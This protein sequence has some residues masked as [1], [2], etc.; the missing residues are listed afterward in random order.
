MPEVPPPRPV[1]D[2]LI[3][4]AGISGIGCAAY[5]RRLMPQKTFGILE[6][7]GDL[8]GTWDLFR[9]PGIR[10]DSDL[11]TFAYEFKPWKSRNSMAAASEIKDYLEETADEYGIR[12]KISFGRKVIACDWSS[13]EGL[14]T[15]TAETGSGTEIWRCRWIFSAT[16]YYDYDN[17]YRPDFPEEGAFAGQIVH[18]QA[19]PRDLDYAGRRVAVIGSGATAVTLLP[20]LAEKAAHVTQVQRTPSYVLPL[21]KE[22]P[23][24]KRLRP[25]FSANAVHK[26]LRRKSIWQQYIFYRLCR[27]F[28]KAMRN[29]IRKANVKSLPAGFPVDT[30]FN[31]PYDPWDQRLCFVP[32]GDL[33]KRLS[34]GSCS[35]VTGEVARLTK[36]GIEME[37]GTHVAA[38]VIVTATGLNVKL[39]GGARYSLNGVPVDFSDRLIFKGLM[40]DGVPNLAISVGY[41]N[42]SWTLKVGLLC[43]YLCR[44]LSEMDQ[45]GMDICV[46][47]RPARAMKTRPLLDFKAG[48]VQRALS[49]LPKQGDRFPW[50][51]TANYRE[52]ERMMKRGQ[53]IVPELRLTAVPARPLEAA[54]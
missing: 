10:S 9:Y 12:D 42:S 47:V 27:R 51:M 35:I 1:L 50:E 54:E 41:T 3:L 20:A 29:V 33:F 15:V 30:H 8:G 43:Q 14:W 23:L 2:V 7:R 6:M 25:F 39:A 53:V 45:R 44:L 18:P 11:Y 36:T 4:G 48:Y 22:D 40:L 37:D 13:D 31:P 24:L 52:D 32:D 38:D 17:G 26:I 46:P 49:R 21:P 16:G 19:W 28:P 34:D 5:L